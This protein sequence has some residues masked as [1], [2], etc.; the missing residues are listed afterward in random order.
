MSAGDAVAVNPMP[1]QPVL[2]FAN[3][4]LRDGWFVQQAL[5]HLRDPYVIAADGGARNAQRSGQTPDLVIGDMDSLSNQELDA[6]A[7]SGAH[8]ERYPEEKNETDL[9]LALQ[10]ACERSASVIRIIGATGSRV[11]QSLGNIYLLALPALR[12]CDVRILSGDQQLW[13]ARPGQHTLHG[14]TDDTLSLLPL[15]ADAQGIST[16]GLYYPL[17]DDTLSFGPARGMSN[18]FTSEQPTF[19]FKQ[20]LLLVI[21]THGTPE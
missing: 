17:D 10:R 15:T 9:E 2:I 8:I 6:L 21:H 5:Q 12:D 1:A 4:D 3:G 19:S 11:D 20:G 16:Q 14:H 7:R 13:L 18:V